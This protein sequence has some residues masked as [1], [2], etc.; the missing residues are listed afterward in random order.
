MFVAGNLIILPCFAR[1]RQLLRQ[2]ELGHRILGQWAQECYTI[3]I[4]RQELLDIVS[5]RLRNAPEQIVHDYR[6]MTPGCIGIEQ[7]HLV[8]R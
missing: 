5:E 6:V 1:E 2:L 8:P 7:F 4:C 3:G